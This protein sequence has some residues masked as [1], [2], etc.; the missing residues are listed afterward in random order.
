MT[1]VPQKQSS[2]AASSQKSE[3]VGLCS[4]S[5][6]VTSELVNLALGQPFLWLSPD[7]TLKLSLLAKV[8]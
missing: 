3:F 8:L 5:G 1:L 4:F 7:Y 2:P 6:Q